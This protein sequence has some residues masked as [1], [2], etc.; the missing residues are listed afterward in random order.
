MNGV[1]AGIQSANV[2]FNFSCIGVEV[3]G[4]LK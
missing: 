2:Y 3:E 1:A 4:R